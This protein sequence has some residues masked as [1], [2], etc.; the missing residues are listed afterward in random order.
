M[1]VSVSEDQ[2]VSSWMLNM[3]T[4]GTM[5]VLVKVVAILWGIWFFRNKKV[6]EDRMVT[7]QMVVN[8]G[9]T[10]IPEWNQAKK[11]VQYVGVSKSA[12]SNQMHKWKSPET[13]SF[14]IYV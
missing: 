1:N 9:K 3:L 5:E 11:Q 2:T 13:G 4:N 6:W 7:S 12:K 8:W 14:K 10:R